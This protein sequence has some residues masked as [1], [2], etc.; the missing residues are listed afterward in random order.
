M[1]K[2][3]LITKIALCIIYKSILIVNKRKKETQKK[4]KT[5]WKKSWYDIKNDKC[6]P[7]KLQNSIQTT[8]KRTL[9]ST[10]S[11]KNITT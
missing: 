1:L 6:Y 5:K 2:D 11:N 7:K 9:R 8:S 10:K 3:S 4:T